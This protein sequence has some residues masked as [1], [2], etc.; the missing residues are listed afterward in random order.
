M[1]DGLE[2]RVDL[3]CP[4]VTPEAACSLFN[5]CLAIFLEQ[6]SP[7]GRVI[8]LDE[9]HKYMTSSAESQA[10]TST[11][12]STVRLQRH[13]GARIVVATQEPTVSSALL[14]LCSV[15]IIHR[16]TSPAWLR[17]LQAHVALP[18]QNQVTTRCRD[19]PSLDQTL[20]NREELFGEI[21]RL[22][23]GEAFIF[24][25]S[26]AVSIG[27]K[28]DDCEQGSTLDRACLKVRIRARLSEDG[29][30]SVVAR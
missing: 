25:P 10:L 16:F 3:S 28:G 13:V 18:V 23:T 5:T 7:C 17:A 1:R 19:R 30:K 8:A 15:T 9:A 20:S 4:C 29:G 2:A 12:L 6:D 24:A 11:L 22:K 27:S 26:A 14:D 21:V